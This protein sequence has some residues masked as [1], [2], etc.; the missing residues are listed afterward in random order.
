MKK[1]YLFFVLSTATTFA[2]DPF[3]TTWQVDSFD[4][5]ITVPTLETLNYNYTID[6]GDGTILNNVTGDASHFYTTPGIYTVSITRDFPAIYFNGEFGSYDIESVEQWGDIQWA[7]ME[8][9]FKDCIFLVVNATDIPD[10]SQVTNLSEMFKGCRDSFNQPLENWDVSNITNMSF[11]FYGT[12]L[13]NQPLNNWDVSNVVD[14]NGIFSETEAFNQS[15]ESWDVSNVVTMNSM[16]YN[17]SSFNQPLN[18]WDVSNVVDMNLMFAHALYFNQPLNNWNV[19]NVVDMSEMFDL[20]YYFNQPLDNWDVS[21]VTDMSTMFYGATNFNQNLAT[22]DFNSNNDFENFVSLSGLNSINYDNLLARFVDMG[23]Q[24]MYLGAEELQYCDEAS[25]NELIDD[26]GWEI[27]GDSLSADC[28]LAIAENDLYEF[29]EIYPVPAKDFLLL[30]IPGGIGVSQVEVFDTH[31]KKIKI[32][33]DSSKK[34]NVE[35]IA[36]GHYFIKI[37]TNRETLVKKFIKL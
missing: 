31:G 19:S 29:I 6:F 25:R 28:N 21:N 34:I 2:Q 26:L 9:A 18:N 10:L 35:N 4:L 3:V 33:S 23:L 36:S 14:M 13:F 20:A 7:T 27:Y 5:G 11:M 17:A 30:K 1:L 32:I 16:F 15:L 12:D 8:S 22:W 24:D 37:Y